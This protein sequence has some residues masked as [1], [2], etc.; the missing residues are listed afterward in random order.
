MQILLEKANR[1]RAHSRDRDGNIIILAAVSMILLFAFAAFAIDVGYMTMTRSQLQNASD[2]G[3]LAGALKLIDG[4][5]PKPVSSS[6]VD[7]NARQAAVDL[8]GDNA[9]GDRSSVYVNKSSDIQLGHRVWDSSTQTWSENWGATPYDLIRVAA[10]RDQTASN[11][12][13]NQL[14]LFFAGVIG[15]RTASISV[16]ATATISPGSGFH[17]PSGSSI[18]AP[19][20]PI[21]LDHPSWDLL[22]SGVGSDNYS[23]DPNTG[24]VSSGSDGIKEIDIY[25]NGTTDLPPGNRGTVKIG[26]SNNSTSTLGDQ[27]RNGLTAA[28]LANY[29]NGTLTTDNGPI[30]LEGNPGLSAGIKDDLAAII[31]QPRAI[32]LFTAVSGPGNNAVY[33]IDRF[34]GI[35]VLY[36]QLTGS[37]NNKKVIVQPATLTSDTVVAG[38][39]SSTTTYIYS[40]PR[41]IH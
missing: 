28:E 31:G 2:A 30:S 22:M 33:T 11:Y 36:V 38:T 20:M 29:P 3:A 23:Y 41:L 35:R 1:Q 39:S 19:V 8:A 25:P 21:T 32:P 15:N 7:T 6:T 27:I 26:V 4:L 17:I 34:V 40:R 12:G 37:P 5:G 9:A 10:R 13:D 16:N 18:T 24:T 14:P